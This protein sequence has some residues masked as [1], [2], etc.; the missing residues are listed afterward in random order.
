MEAMIDGVWEPTAERLASCHEEIIRLQKL[1]E[2]LN[3][4]SILE[5]DNLV[6]H[7]TRFDL[8]ALITS[9]VRQFLPQAREKGIALV[10]DTGNGEAPIYA[11]YDRLMQVLVNLISNGIKYTDAGSI[12][13]TIRPLAPA[14]TAAGIG[15]EPPHYEISVTDTGIGISEDALPHIFER[16]YRADKSR[17]RDTGGAGIGLTIA[18]A[19]VAAHGGRISAESRAN[20]P[21][22]GSVFRV[23]I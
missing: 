22:Q 19:I 11:D 8:V 20:A 2:D 23:V 4:L 3:L 10:T 1:V 18:A 15:G 5:R 9:A 12:R 13:I 17:N 21:S 16:F 7:K 14:G 6:L